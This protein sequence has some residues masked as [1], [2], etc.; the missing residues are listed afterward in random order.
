M[1]TRSTAPP[2]SVGLSHGWWQVSSG[3]AGQGT[4]MT[5]LPVFEEHAPS[6]ATALPSRQAEGEPRSASNGSNGNVPA[7]DSPEVSTKP[8]SARANRQQRRAHLQWSPDDQGVNAPG[9]SPS[10][11]F[12]KP[13]VRNLS[14]LLTAAQAAANDLLFCHNTSLL[15]CQTICKVCCVVCL[16]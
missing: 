16:Q 6:S 15:P 4:H 9:S 5:G 7:P 10:S 8:S 12:A 11:G 1:P 14:R 2:P 13:P 3:A